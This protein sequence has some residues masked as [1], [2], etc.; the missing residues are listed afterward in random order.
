MTGKPHTPGASDRRNF[1]IAGRGYAYRERGRWL[2]WLPDD[3]EIVGS[4][5]WIV[6]PGRESA[7]RYL[8]TGHAPMGAW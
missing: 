7:V 1:V 8:N 2:A 3:G 6:C 4:R 5:G